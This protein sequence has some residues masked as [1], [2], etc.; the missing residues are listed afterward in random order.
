MHLRQRGITSRELE[1]RGLGGKFVV[2]GR[3]VATASD[4]SRAFK[5]RIIMS[6]LQCSWGSKLDETVA[7]PKMPRSAL[8][9]EI[10]AKLGLGKRGTETQDAEF[11]KHGQQIQRGATTQNY[12]AGNQKHFLKRS[13]GTSS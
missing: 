4:C 1:D 2:C 8:P 12:S 13:S 3:E 9:P 6:G 11:Y 7:R 5:L 10:R